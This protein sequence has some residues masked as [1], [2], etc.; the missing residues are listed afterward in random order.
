MQGYSFVVKPDQ[1]WRN[2]WTL[3]DKHV[4]KHPAITSVTCC[5]AKGKHRAGCVTEGFIR[6]ARISHFLVCIQSEKD[7]TVYAQQMTWSVPCEGHSQLKW[8]A[9]LI[10]SSFICSC[11]KCEDNNLHCAGK[12]RRANT[13]SHVSSM[14]LGMRSSVKIESPTQT[15]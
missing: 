12:R 1:A 11:G 10:P 15:V 2:R 4:K 14:L 3:K 5:C 6:N 8:Q 13:F 9:V 7:H